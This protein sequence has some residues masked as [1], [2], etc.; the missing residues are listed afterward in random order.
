MFCR[1]IWFGNWSISVATDNRLW[2]FKLKCYYI[3]YIAMHLDKLN[4]C[5]H[6]SHVLRSPIRFP[7]AVYYFSFLF[8]L[9]WQHDWRSGCLINCCAARRGF[10]SFTDQIFV[11]PII[12]CSGSTQLRYRRNSKYGATLKK[13]HI[14]INTYVCKQT[15]KTE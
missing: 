1:L 10:D 7:C 8:S 11:W 14:F 5:L 2:K 12:N 9:F 13:I 15:R 6:N 3:M 4:S